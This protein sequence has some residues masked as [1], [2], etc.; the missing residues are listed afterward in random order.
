MAT[1]SD[2]AKLAGVSEATVSFVINNTKNVTPEVHQRV[3]SAVKTLGYRPNLIA[4]SLATNHT[5][6][7]AM[8]V[9][10]LKNPH[11]CEML[12]GA[13]Q[14]ASQHGYIVSVLSMSSSNMRTVADLVARGVDGAILTLVED[15]PAN[16]LKERIPCVT[17]DSHVTID[18]RQAIFDMVLCLKQH[19]HEKIAFLSG[20]PL[21][22]KHPRQ[23]H[24]REALAYY[25][26]PCIESLF[27]D[28]GH[29]YQTNEEAGMHTMQALLNRNQS[30][31]AVYALNDLMAIGA[32]KVLRANSYS[33]PKDVSIIG[34]DHLH[35]LDY[36][37]PPLSTLDVYSYDTGSALMTLLIETIDNL[38][39]TK[40]H[41]EAKFLQKESIAQAPL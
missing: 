32:A 26:L 9:D 38:P 39:K 29:S 16:Y 23:I 37:H 28:E 13:Q 30:F 1:R 11:Y 40:V 12:E 8:L 36:F 18:C 24:F 34:S 21:E 33:I 10:N 31:T 19:G 4:R 27:V 14:V 3:M 22:E 20:L 6:H 41:I 5:R 15:P 35:I 2:V 25:G 7:V 17:A